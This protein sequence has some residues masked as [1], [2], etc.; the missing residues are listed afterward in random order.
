MND[1]SEFPLSRPL[2]ASVAGGEAG[3]IDFY[4]RYATFSWPW[5]WRRTAV[6]GA[7]GVFAALSFGLSHGVYMKD[8]TRGVAVGWRVGVANFVLVGAGPALAAWVRHLGLAR[9]IEVALVIGAV[10]AGMV[11]TPIANAWAFGYHD[12]EMAAHQHATSPSPTAPPRAQTSGSPQPDM[13][14]WTQRSLNAAYTLLFWFL[15]SG[16]LA[17]R[18]YLAEPKRWAE[19]ERRQALEALS[20]Q[21]STAD[22]RLAVLQAQVEPHFLFNTLASVRSLINSDPPRAAQTIEALAD[23]LR[24]TLPKLRADTGTVLSTLGEQFDICASYLK[25]M[26]LRLGERLTTTIELSKPLRNVP[27]PPLILISL[28]ENAIKHG[29]EPKMGTTH[30]SL[31]AETRDG[32][33]GA[34]LEVTVAD[35]GAGL[36]LGMGEGTGLANIRAQLMTRFDESAAVELTTREGGGVLARLVLPLEAVRA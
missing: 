5:T 19:Y 18:P 13:G 36:K 32:P 29:A 11:L 21:K 17:L 14:Q 2:P 9:R 23:H 10:L 7:I 31:T 8:W 27:F 24:A 22:L 1:G 30:V 6:F 26:Q 3:F 25:L 12:R 28:V 4:Q 16:G 34:R 35:D 20:L 33:S 15:A